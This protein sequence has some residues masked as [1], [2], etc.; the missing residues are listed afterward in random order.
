MP[1]DCSPKKSNQVILILFLSLVTKPRPVLA[2]SCKKIDGYDYY[3]I[4][5]R[6]S[7]HSFHQNFPRTPIW[8][9]NGLYPD[10]H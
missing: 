1:S 10:H 8:G 3:E 4:E 7:Y 9:Y 5:M 6:A 2:K